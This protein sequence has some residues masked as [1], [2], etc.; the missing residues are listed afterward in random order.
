MWK[1][2]HTQY[3]SRKMCHCTT[4]EQQLIEIGSVLT[5]NA[6]KVGSEN[7]TIARQSEKIKKFYA[8]IFRIE[9]AKRAPPRKSQDKTIIMKVLISQ[10]MKSEDKL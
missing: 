4:A 3:H 7:R 1:R 8:N 6:N 9:I 5:Q 10:R 2:S